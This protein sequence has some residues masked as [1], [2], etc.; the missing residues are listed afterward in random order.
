MPGI[1][2][3]PYVAVVVDVAIAFKEAIARYV[4]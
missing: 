3:Q 1:K 2:K 4:G